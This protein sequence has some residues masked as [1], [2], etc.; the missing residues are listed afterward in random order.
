MVKTIGN[1]LTWTAEAASAAGSH[2]AEA[3][4]RMGGR[5]T[6]APQVRQITF[7]DLLAAL[8]AGFEDFMALRSDV[9]ALVVIYPLIGVALV[10][11]AVNTEL[12]PYLFPMASGFALIGPVAATG[13]YELSRR[14]EAGEPTR[15]SD[16]L[17][18]LRSPSMAPILALGG[19]LMAIFVI[20]ML[21]AGMIWQ[22]TLG[23]QPPSEAGFL[24]QVLGTNAGWGMI[25]LGIPI[26]AVFAALVLA[27]AVVSVPLLVDRNT[28]LP[29]ALVTSWRVTRTNPG[30]VLA[31]G[32]IVAGLLVI[33]SLPL[34][35]GLIVVMPVLGHASWHLYRRAVAPR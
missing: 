2:V 34:F 10:L 25:L 26:G 14:R 18:P 13:L 17:T 1:P 15:W 22:V 9:L 11:I 21:V 7:D 29:M 5:E 6:E 3:T 4:R 32:A 24:A 33:G 8:A 31:W 35:L 23:A 19:L 27:L 20:W 12:L 28:G 16:A 30:P